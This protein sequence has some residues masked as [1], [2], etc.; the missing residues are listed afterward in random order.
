MAGGALSYRIVVRLGKDYKALC[1]IQ[2]F[3]FGMKYSSR[4]RKFEHRQTLLYYCC[5]P[6]FAF[7]FPG[8]ILTRI[9]FNSLFTFCL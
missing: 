7:I 2:N 9:E 4:L 8:L 6:V 3:I 5:Q 1:K